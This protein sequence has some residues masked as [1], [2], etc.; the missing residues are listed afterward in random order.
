MKFKEIKHEKYSSPASFRVK[1]D[2]V[3]KYRRVRPKPREFTQRAPCRL[4]ARPARRYVPYLAIAATTYPDLDQRVREY[5]AK[6][7]KFP[8]N[9]AKRK[10]HPHRPKPANNNAKNAARRAKR[11]RWIE[12]TMTDNSQGAQPALAQVFNAA[13][14]RSM[15][16]QTD[17]RI[18]RSICRDQRTGRRNTQ[19]GWMNGP[20]GR[21]CERR[22]RQ[23]AWLNEGKARHQQ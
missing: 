3:W 22:R 12:A 21:E 18:Y 4:L 11:K 14:V 13:Q 19:N 8:S 23:R 20:G 1:V 17:V 16:S 15:Q 6:G 10:F 2:G 7:V 5:I 9:M